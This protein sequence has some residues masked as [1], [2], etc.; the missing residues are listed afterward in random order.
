MNPGEAVVHQQRVKK[1]LFILYSP[2]AE[3]ISGVEPCS[4]TYLASVVLR[5]FAHVLN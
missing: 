5:S 4:D 1:V 3:L 2:F